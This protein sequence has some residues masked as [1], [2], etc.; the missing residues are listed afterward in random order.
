MTHRKKII[1]AAVAAIII[2][3]IVAVVA[4]KAILA[5]ADANKVEPSWKTVKGLTSAHEENYL[6]ALGTPLAYTEAEVLKM[7]EE[8]HPNFS[9]MRN[10]WPAWDAESGSNVIYYTDESGNIQ[11]ATE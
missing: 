3:V 11:I 2:L 1:V 10:P 7:Y 8:E 4:P 9:N 5:T 6:M